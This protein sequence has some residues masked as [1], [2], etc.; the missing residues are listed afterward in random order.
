MKIFVTHDKQGKIYSIG[1]PAAQFS[2]SMGIVAG[3]RGQIVSTFDVAEIEHPR[4]LDK[5]LREF[6]VNLT[7]GKRKLVK[8]RGTNVERTKRKSV[9]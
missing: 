2:G 3:K 5:Y 6:R 1:M 4:H 9:G 7:S 8:N